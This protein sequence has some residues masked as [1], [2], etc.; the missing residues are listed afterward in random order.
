MTA[1]EFQQLDTAAKL[2]QIF[3]CLAVVSFSSILIIPFKALAALAALLF[4]S[5]AVGAF[6]HRQITLWS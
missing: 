3:L 5:I 1:E 4:G 6:V 2:A